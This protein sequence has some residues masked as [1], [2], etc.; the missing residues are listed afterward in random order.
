MRQHGKRRTGWAARVGALLAVLAGGPALAGGNLLVNGSFEEPRA[1]RSADPMP[2]GPPTLTGWRLVEGKAALVPYGPWQPAEGQGRQSLLLGDATG[3][4]TLEQVVPTQPGRYYLVSGWL[5]HDPAT[6]GRAEALAQLWINGQPLAPLG[7]DDTR[8]TLQNMR[9]TLFVHRF[10]ATEPATPLRI[11]GA[12]A[13]LDGLAVTLTGGLEPV[14]TFFPIDLSRRLTHRLSDPQMN[15]PG[16]DLADLADS[17]TPESPLAVLA[18]V[19]FLVEGVILVGPGQFEGRLTQGPVTLVR[20]V[21]GIP[22]GR[23]A[24]RLYF[25]HATN[26]SLPTRGTKVGA[27]LVDYTDGTSVEIPIRYGIDVA[28]W[29][30]YPDARASDGPVVWRGT[31]EGATRW[32]RLTDFQR[33]VGRP[34]GLQLFMKTWVNPSPDREIESISLVSTTPPSGSGAAAPFL[35]A[36]SGS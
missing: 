23:K 18:G 15:A 22:V 16:N 9:W 25:L 31:S 30:T 7:H 10:R 26:F 8:A 32:G 21:T 2:L 6:R 12:G 3:P 35:V 29:W 24:A 11:S 36:V 28:D 33:A 13:A 20:R 5:A 27:Y 17:L 34:L 14:G 19:P 1:P 4:G